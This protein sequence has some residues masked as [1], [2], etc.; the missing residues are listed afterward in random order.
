MLI[1]KFHTTCT[2]KEGYCF[3][4]IEDCYEG[5]LPCCTFYVFITGTL[6]IMPTIMTFG[7]IIRMFNSVIAM[8][9]LI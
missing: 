3:H 6:R 7:S 4:K 2:S 9:F 1:K 8:R 5:L